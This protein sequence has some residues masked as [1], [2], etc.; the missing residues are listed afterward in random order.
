MDYGP[1]SDVRKATSRDPEADPNE[2]SASGRTGA[3]L[4]TSHPVGLVVVFGLLFMGLTG[5]PEA[6]WF[7]S[8]ALL[9]GGVWGFLL[10]LRH[11]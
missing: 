4:L 8:G 5:M 1:H 10:W 2:V 6:R 7:F 3:G 11:R 9:L